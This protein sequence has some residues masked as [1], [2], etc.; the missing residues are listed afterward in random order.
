MSAKRKFIKLHQDYLIICDFDLCATLLLQRMN[1]WFFY[2]YKKLVKNKVK[3]ALIFRTLDHLNNDLFRIYGKTTIK[4][5]LKLLISKRFIELV[6]NPNKNHAYDNK[7]YYQ[8]NEEIVKETLSKIEWKGGRKPTL[9]GN[10]LNPRQKLTL[11]QSETDPTIIEID[12]RDNKKRQTDRELVEKQ[13]VSQS[14]IDCFLGSLNRVVGLINRLG[15]IEYPLNNSKYKELLMKILA[16][17]HSEEQILFVIQNRWDSWNTEA[18]KKYL[19]LFN[20]T[21]LLDPEKFIFLYQHSLE[22]KKFKEEEVI[23]REK[24]EK[25]RI[26]HNAKLAKEKEEEDRIWAQ[27][28]SR[29]DD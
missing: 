7:N 24:A 11:P 17:G 21:Q 3:H 29:F 22:Y 25:F 9:V 6:N 19:R 27:G 23:K 1:D 5:S 12:N 10:R 13:F 20:P 18:G 26:E 2:S 14:E 28:G 16:D 4:K 8:F 15:G